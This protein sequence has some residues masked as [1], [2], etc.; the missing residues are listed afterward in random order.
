MKRTIMRAA[1][2]GAAAA[3]ALLGVA[4]CGLSGTNGNDTGTA[5]YKGTPTTV[6]RLATPSTPVPAATGGTIM[7]G[8]V[9]VTLDKA[10]YAPTDPITV[11]VNNGLAATI[12]AAD[13]QTACTI[14]TMQQSFDGG[15]RTVGA[16]RLMTPTRLVQI[17]AHTTAIVRLGGDPG[18]LAGSPW[19]AGTYRIQFSYNV[20]PSGSPSPV[21]S[22]EFHIG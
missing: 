7:P 18:Q 9:T 21:Y 19:P 15:W 11:Y 13:H 6:T 4:A 8:Q 3:L 1:T 20:P 2:A 5:T 14:I 12:D 16:C 10:A 22:A 17:A